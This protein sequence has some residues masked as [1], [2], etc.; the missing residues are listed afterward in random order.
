MERI[1]KR[2]KRDMMTYC[3]YVTGSR[4]TAEDIVQEVFVRLI[5]R[6]GEFR[7]GLKNWLFICARNLCLNHLQRQKV[8]SRVADSPRLRSESAE[9][10]MR[11]FVEQILGRLEPEERDLILL[12]ELQGY[13]VRELAELA[14]VSEEAI[15]VRLYRI[16]KKMHKLGRE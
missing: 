2:H 12:R 11:V 14:G 1:Y 5:R 8:A 13:S 4:Q 7:T 16:R 6:K 9:D 3:A 10:H 15:R